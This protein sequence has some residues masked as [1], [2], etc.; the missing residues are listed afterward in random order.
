MLGETAAGTTIREFL[1]QD[2]RE[3]TV[4]LLESEVASTGVPL[5][6]A[7]SSPGSTPRSMADGTAY[8]LTSRTVAPGRLGCAA[9]RL[10]F[11]RPVDD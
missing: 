7:T 4:R 8:V 9:R 6:A 2:L 1:V 3:D 11:P 10:A 5:R